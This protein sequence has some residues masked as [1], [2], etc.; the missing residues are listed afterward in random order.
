QLDT[1]VRLGKDRIGKDRLEL[2]REESAKPGGSAPTPPK[3]VFHKFGEYKHVKLTDKQHSKL[4]SEY[5]E[6]KIT[7]YIRKI[8]EYC[9]QYGK[10]YDD[11]NLT[12]RKWIRKDDENSDRRNHETGKEQ[13]S[14]PKYSTVF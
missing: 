2:G 4:V 6:A 11:Y 9:Q 7:E 14:D 12:V 10:R 8:D 1:Q 5:G 13:Y 3:P